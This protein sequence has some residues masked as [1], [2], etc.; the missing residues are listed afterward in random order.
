MGT[1]HRKVPGHRLPASTKMRL[2][3][4][5]GHDFRFPPPLSFVGLV[6][7]EL[8]AGLLDN[9]LGELRPHRRAPYR[10]T[11]APAASRTRPQPT[12]K[13][14]LAIQNGTAR[15]SA[16]KSDANSSRL[17]AVCLRRRTSSPSDNGEVRE[18]MIEQ[19]GAD[20][21][22]DAL[23]AHP[24]ESWRNGSVMMGRL[25]IVQSP[26]VVQYATA[27]PWP[28]RRRN[29]PWTS[30]KFGSPSSFGISSRPRSP[31]YR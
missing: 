13:W 22:V 9:Q 5:V 11:G 12:M 20:D 31:R 14:S 21:A 24:A 4:R 1:A 26:T 10:R 7:F 28:A 23:Y 17:C 29:A 6:F 25:L 15:L 18:E 8:D 30:P 3:H 16:D 19:S 2:A 27:R